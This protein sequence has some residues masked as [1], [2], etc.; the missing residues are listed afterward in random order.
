MLHAAGGGAEKQIGEE[1]M[2]VGAH[3]DQVASFLLH[4]LD[5]FVGGVAVGQFRLG[6]ECRAALKF[7]ADILQI[8]GVFGDFW[9]DGIRAVGS[10]GP[11]VGDVQQD[12]A[13]VRQLGELLDVLDDR[14]VGG[15][16][17]QR[18]RMVSYIVVDP[19]RGRKLSVRH[20]RPRHTAGFYPPMTARPF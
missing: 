17:V 1:A 14:A 20:G 8:G 6:W 10:G 3:G 4:P 12:Q 11:S 13:A 5:D 9:A 16:A 2:A 18:T 7:G 15:R 19:C